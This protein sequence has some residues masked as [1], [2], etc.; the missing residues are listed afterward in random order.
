MSLGMQVYAS[1][2]SSFT[3]VLGSQ[4]S[5]VLKAASARLIEIF[6][7]EPQ[8]TKAIAWL[9]KLVQDGFPLARDREPASE[10]G[11]GSLLTMQMETNT[12]AVVV[13]CIVEAIA[14]GGH[15]NLG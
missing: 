11:D 8:R 7:D 14:T 3:K 9:R 10:P 12:H 2:L 1:S 13:Y 6:S 4:D 15:K 5:D